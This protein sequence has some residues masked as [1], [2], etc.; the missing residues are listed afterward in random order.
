MTEPIR[1][2]LADDQALVRGALAALLS[3][4]PDLTVVAEVARGDEVVP[5]ALRTRPDVALLDVEMP[6]LD[7]VAAAAALRAALPGCRVLV[8]TTFGRPGYLR[9]A[10]EAGANGFVVKDTPARQ[11]ADAVR[12]V[13]AGLRVVDPTLAA[14]TLA[15]GASPLTDR[16]TEVLRTARGGGTVAELAATLHLSEGTVR[17]HLSAAIG[18]T[19]ARNRADAV[20][21]AEEN[22]WLLGD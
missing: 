4:E 11:L 14:E 22:G 8:V 16:E 10:M 20:R 12:R 7:G 21:V 5:E 1:L 17:N 6:G 9:R 18:K 2:L 3:L 19:G 13:H 15:S